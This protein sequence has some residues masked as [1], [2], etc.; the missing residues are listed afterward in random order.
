MDDSRTNN[1][2]LAAEHA[3]EDEWIDPDAQHWKRERFIPLSKS[4]LIDLLKNDAELSAD[5]RTQ[6]IELCEIVGAT[7]HYDF[8]RKLSDIKD[9]YQY[10]DPDVD[11]VLV[12]TEDQA[13]SSHDSHEVI[14]Q[15]A[16]LMER[17]NFDRLDEN[18]LQQAIN[19][20][21][22]WGV[23]LNVDLAAFESLQ[24]FVRGDIVG[25]R[26]LRTW[27]T[28]YRAKTVDVPIYQRLVV[29][30]RLNETTTDAPATES[31]P[32][33]LKMFKNIPKMDVD[34]MLPG[35][36]VKMSWFDQGKILLPTITGLGITIFKLVMAIIKGIAL[37]T[38]TGVYGVIALLGF[39]GGTFGYGAKSFFG[40]LR[41]KDKY[42]LKLTKSLYYQNLDN[43]AGV[44]FR[45]LDEAEEQEFCEAI[46]AYFLL[47]KRA[48]QHGWTKQQLD[49]E[50][51]G[52][53]KKATGV[54]V[55]F[56]IQDALAKLQRL[57]LVESSDQGRLQSLPIRQ[58]LKKLD[59]SWDNFFCHS[60]AAPRTMTIPSRENDEPENERRSAAG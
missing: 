49:R 1:V 51:E 2:A 4:R 15:I 26:R 18:D 47:W 34:M 32:I 38:V 3:D 24:V 46:L 16:E 22:Q 28:F 56:E 31:R 12:E 37:I 7:F 42:N 45:I 21:S 50:A 40:Y 14:D 20:A 13:A 60:N 44:F 30:F 9:A 53:L 29:I 59:E 36:K 55:D 52:F 8:H 57:E 11:G 6:F 33:F 35:A 39:I 19:V 54:D 17:A 48:D 10:F 43:N 58:A 23:Q 25:H 27:K 5:E 41:T